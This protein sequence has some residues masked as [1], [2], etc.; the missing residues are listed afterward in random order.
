MWAKYCKGFVG[1][2]QVQNVSA[3][4][5]WPTVP[6]KLRILIKKQSGGT[7]TQKPALVRHTNLLRIV[8]GCVYL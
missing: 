8:Y 1:D 5:G 6:A 7:P 3:A 4:L 2:T